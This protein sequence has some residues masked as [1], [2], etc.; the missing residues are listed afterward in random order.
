VDGI[1]SFLD[2]EARL[3]WMRMEER[4][5]QM[6]VGTEEQSRDQWMDDKI[7]HHLI[8]RMRQCSRRGDFARVHAYYRKRANGRSPFRM[9][10]MISIIS[11][12][13]MAELQINTY[14][15]RNPFPE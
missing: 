14:Y 5:E 9:R 7:Q 4:Q 12:N 13:E 10:N 3:K 15:N 2:E 6:Q 1:V 8:N 11:W